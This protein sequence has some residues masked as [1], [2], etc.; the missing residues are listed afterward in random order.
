MCATVR[1]H[2]A[3][4]DLVQPHD[5]RDR[6]QGMEPPRDPLPGGSGLASCVGTLGDG[7]PI[8]TTTVG[9][10]TFTV[11]ASDNAGNT[12]SLT[13]TYQ[14]VY[15]FGGFLSPVSNPPTLNTVTAGQ[16]VPVRFGLS[17]DQGLE[18]FAAGYPK[19][20]RIPCETT[21]DPTDVIATTSAGESGLSYDTT[22][23]EYTYVW[24]TKR[25]WRKSCHELVVKL[26]DGTVRTALFQFR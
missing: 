5:G 2:I 7:S 22:T 15:D 23:D 20:R 8:N 10:R 6:H 17:G 26:D 14:V 11:N 21:G 1:P 4:E 9:S 16:G 19:S 25:R 12:A 24:K 3:E 18:I 13:H